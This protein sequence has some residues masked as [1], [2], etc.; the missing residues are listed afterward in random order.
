MKSKSIQKF[1]NKE[2]AEMKEMIATIDNHFKDF[3]QEKS[4]SE[5][6]YLRLKKLLTNFFFYGDCSSL[7]KSIIVKKKTGQSK[8]WHPF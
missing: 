4:I 8:C 1:S 6:E 3:I 2:S 7:S 5:G